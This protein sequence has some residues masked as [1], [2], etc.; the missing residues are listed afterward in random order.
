MA[1]DDQIYQAFRERVEEFDNEYD[2][3]PDTLD[4]SI[5][6]LSDMEKDELWDLLIDEDF[7]REEFAEWCEEHNIKYH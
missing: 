5:D 6:H 2:F 7:D 1:T 4:K 3:N